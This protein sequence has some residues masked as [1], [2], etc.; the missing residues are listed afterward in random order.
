MDIV[1]KTKLF[2]EDNID[3][4]WSDPFWL[5]QHVLLVENQI[6]RVLKKEIWANEMVCI[7]SCRLHDIWHYPIIEGEDHAVIWERIARDFLAKEWLDQNLIDQVSHCVRSHRC[8]D[9]IPNSL[10]AKILAF[11]DSA[12]HMQDSMY[13]EIAKDGRIDYAMAKLERDYRDL[14]LFPELKKE[15]ENLYISWKKLLEE[16]KL[17]QE[18]YSKNF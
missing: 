16:Y 9:I 5:K 3:K 4:F 17:F 18:N 15:Y 1:A 10:E 14:N 11:C 13:I 12:S 6:K 7:L 2:F 8:K